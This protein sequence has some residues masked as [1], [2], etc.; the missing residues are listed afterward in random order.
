MIDC[1]KRF[2][3]YVTFDTQ[4]E[5]DSKTVPTT[6]GQLLFAKELYSEIKEMGIDEITLSEK[7]YIYCKLPS[8]ITTK[9]KAV[10]FIA[11]MDTSGDF[12]GKNVKP[13]IVKNYDGKDIQLLHSENLKISP[14][15]FPVLNNYIGQDIIVAGGDTLLGADDKAGIAEIL[16]AID[17]FIKNPNIPHGD[18]Y[19]A[20]T[21]DEEVGRGMD[22]FE[23]ELFPADFAYTIDGG[24]VGELEYENFNAA[25]AIVEITGES[26]HP[27]YAKGIMKNAALI[28]CELVESL[29]KDQTPATTE[30][31]DGYFHVAGFK[32]SVKDAELTILIRDFIKTGF[33]ERKEFLKNCCDNIN[34]KHGNVLKLTF[35]DE[36]YNM[37]EKLNSNMQIVYQAQRS[38]EIVG[39]VPKIRPIRGGTDGCRLSFMG[40]PCPN[41]FAGGHNFHGP[42]EFI[43][44]NSMAAAVSVIVSIASEAHKI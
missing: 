7:G 26:V 30:G 39:V 24:E 27:G 13:R 31:Y 6:K 20:F 33:L 32:G 36:Y 37:M 2:L 10:G 23:I 14:D 25:R 42:F 5:Y 34:E 12:S 16:T 17:Y 29:P 35:I 19:F 22:H 18:I 41:I 43:P 28:G 21:P 9:T 4:S 15:R 8:N 1:V 11:H 3:S 40:I 44:V 38:M